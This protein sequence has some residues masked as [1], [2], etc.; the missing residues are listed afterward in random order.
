MRVAIPSSSEC[1]SSPQRPAAAGWLAVALALALGCGSAD[2]AAV[3]G[4]AIVLVTAGGLRADVAGDLSRIGELDTDWRGSAVVASSE[5]TATLASLL[6]GVTPWKHQVL[7]PESPARTALATLP[8][9]LGRAGYRSRVHLGDEALALLGGGVETIDDP[10]SEEAGELLGDGVF[11]WFHFTDAEFVR[12]RWK[13]ARKRRGFQP[14]ELLVWADPE[15]ALP[16]AKRRAI[17][18][19]YDSGVRR[20][21]QK[22]GRLLDRLRTSPAW[23][24]ATVA[25]TATH[26]LE[27]GEHGQ[28]LSG[29]NLGRKAIEV[30]LFIRLGD[31]LGEL[32]EPS[33]GRVAQTRLWTTLLEVTGLEAAPVHSPSLF[34]R[35]EPVVLSELYAR[36]GVNRFSLLSGDLQLHWTTRFAPAE[37]DYYKARRVEAGDRPRILG[38]PSRRI[39]GRLDEAFRATP[40]LSGPPGSEPELVLERWREDGGV[41]EVEDQAE[42]RR[43]AVLLRRHWTRFEV[44]ERT[45]GEARN[46]NESDSGVDSGASAE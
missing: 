16:D 41:E 2:K 19:A 12:K 24:R 7:G 26:G 42:A 9:E 33:G 21:D 8:E 14:S 25:V 4:G 23:N 44:R 35:A 45:P 10:F 34:Q 20:L 27:L 46:A 15:T 18:R 40:P 11:L 29:E 5:P 39:F 31:G 36:N 17:R 37:S 30:P 22:V 6:F 13:R 32:A 3:R 38:E 43:L 28:I 1:R